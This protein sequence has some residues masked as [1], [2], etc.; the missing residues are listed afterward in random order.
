MGQAIF[1]IGAARVGWCSF[2]IALLLAA[3]GSADILSVDVEDPPSNPLIMKLTVHSTVPAKIYVSYSYQGA[4]SNTVTFISKFFCGATGDQCAAGA[5]SFATSTPVTI[6]RLRASTT[7]NYTA[8]AVDVNGN[9]SRG[10]TGSF[11]TSGLSGALA[12]NS[13]NWTN[14][15][16]RFT[17]P[18]II[19]P[20]SEKNLTSTG[21]IQSFNGFVAL[22]S[23]AQIVWQFQ[24]P[25]GRAAGN[26]IQEPNLQSSVN[27]VGDFP[28]NFI[29]VENGPNGGIGGGGADDWFTEFRPDGAILRT[30]ASSTTYQLPL[31][32]PSPRVTQ[33]FFTQPPLSSPLPG[34]LWGVSGPVRDVVRL[35]D[36]RVIYLSRIVKDPFFDAHLVAA[37]GTRLQQGY[38]L[39]L[40]D[41][42]TG[43]DHIVWDPFLPDGAGYPL[44][45]PIAERTNNGIAPDGTLSVDANTTDPSAAS[46]TPTPFIAPNGTL[47]TE[48]WLHA[49][50]AQQGSSGSFLLNARYLDTTLA[51]APAPDFQSFTVAWRIGRFRSDFIFRDQ[52]DMPR[53]PHDV[54]E[55]PNGN[56]LYFD[57]GN[58]RPYP[59]SR[60]PIDSDYDYSRALELKLDRTSVPWTATKVW[61][62]R[63]PVND[64]RIYVYANRVGSVT[65][66]TNGNTLVLFGA[67]AAIDVNTST[68]LGVLASQGDG[69]SILDP[70]TH[71]MTFHLVE[72]P[73]ASDGASVASLEVKL[74]GIPPPIAPATTPAEF[75]TGNIYRAYPVSTLFGECLDANPPVVACPANINVPNAP[76]L[77][78]AAP[79]V[80]SATASD[81]C[82]PV[83]DLLLPTRSDGKAIGDPFP[84]GTT[85]ITWKAKDAPGN[86]GSCTQS[87]TISDAEPPTLAFGVPTPAANANGWNDTNVSVPFSAADNCGVQSTTPAASPAV[88]SQ[89]GVAVTT[90]VTVT[91]IN[92]NTSSFTS[93]AVNI[94]KTPPVILF[95]GRTPPPDA[96]GWV[97]SSVTMIWNCLDALSGA[98]SP[99][100]AAVVSAEGFNQLASGD[101]QDQAGNIASDTQGG[102]NIDET[103]PAISI[104]APAANGNYILNSIQ[105]AS[106]SCLDALSGVVGCNGP[107]P[108]GAAF[109]TETV[110]VK[111]FVV[112]ASDEAGNASS[113]DHSYT[114]QYQPAGANC[115]GAPGHSILDPIAS[116]G[117]KVFKQ[118]ATVPAK[119][120]VCDANGVSIQDPVTSFE[121][122]Q[123]ISGTVT[124]V[125][126]ESVSS[127][128][129]DSGFRWDPI[130][131]QEIF[132]ISTKGLAANQTYVFLIGLNDGT[133]IQFQFGLK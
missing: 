46:G 49:N 116:D 5:A 119:F 64:G 56:L 124:E 13:Y 80:G 89:E 69:S 86:V 123:T 90:A 41:P 120:R 54:Q 35:A 99:S 105:V 126:D 70:A 66:L 14:P 3:S 113:L 130:E 101:C 59:T 127:T 114:V 107:V 74:P 26:L 129:P 82:D 103:P 58:G 36:G 16:M 97:N 25:D 63:H 95:A 53:H 31:K 71:S 51:L 109:D 9:K 88:L 77:C 24:N 72:A 18:L 85:T 34:A 78:S 52:S 133:Q 132:N 22:D 125:V 110:G 73:V 65:R 81:D 96:Y 21:A 48:D 27:G 57:N 131:Q 79:G 75:V 118:G 40:W 37:P 92:G 4:N 19:L 15:G 83:P 117:S 112:S 12:R 7:Y 84:V 67:D 50:S 28:F 100:V 122:W 42:S 33:I 45:D 2:S 121:L 29:F 128:T 61:E 111:D 55:L 102:I 43:D 68:S 38:G 87:V 39:R 62:Y 20:H 44:F 60:A 104:D 1:R 98:V 108:N 23:D 115:L 47:Q 93:P 32:P 76:G 8:W 106:W 10:P 91:D 94:D 6:G 17:V 11:T 30:I